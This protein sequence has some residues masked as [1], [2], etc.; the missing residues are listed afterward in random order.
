MLGLRPVI[1][2]TLR[3][4]FVI[5]LHIRPVMKLLDKVLAGRK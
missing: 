2:G 5:G 3:I 1:F 4:L